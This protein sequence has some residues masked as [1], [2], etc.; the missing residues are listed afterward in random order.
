MT[1]SGLHVAEEAKMAA[2]EGS[3][4]GGTLVSA[5]GGGLGGAG[6]ARRG[7]GE[8]GLRASRGRSE[9]SFSLSG[10]RRSVRCQAKAER[11]LEA[12]AGGGS[13][14]G[15]GWGKGPRAGARK[16]TGEEDRKGNRVRR[17]AGE[18]P[19]SRRALPA[20]PAPAFAVEP[21]GLCLVCLPLRVVRLC[22]PQAS[23]P[24]K[25]SFLLL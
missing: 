13:S 8:A 3:G 15:R 19:A 21:V 1:L 20:L 10:A 24:L 6:E 12:W 11:G 16:E 22:S 25:L 7:T 17:R 9:L 23:P 4:A 14:E 2:A 5:A 18:Q